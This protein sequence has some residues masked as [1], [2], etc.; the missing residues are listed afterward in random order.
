MVARGTTDRNLKV[1]ERPAQLGTI[2]DEAVT[3]LGR[4]IR[5]ELHR[6]L[7]GLVTGVVTGVLLLVVALGFVV[8]GV[9]R[10]GDALAQACGQWFGNAL[11]GDATVG[12]ILL[13][14]PLVG[15]VILRLRTR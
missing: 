6:A 9:T 1:D 4:A 15:L 14:V 3:A 2:V 11:L 12:L 5:R 13:A 10:L 8:A 7:L